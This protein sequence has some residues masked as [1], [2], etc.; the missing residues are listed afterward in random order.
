VFALATPAGHLWLLSVP[1]G[2]L[3][4]DVI[5]VRLDSSTRVLGAGGQ[6]LDLPTGETVVDLR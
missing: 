6:P 4:K 3:P 5:T 2:A 1:I